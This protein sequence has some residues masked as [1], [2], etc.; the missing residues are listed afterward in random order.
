LGYDDDYCDFNRGYGRSRR[1]R[2][3]VTIINNNTT[4]IVNPTPNASP[5]P[6]VLTPEQI[7]E[8]RRR[9]ARTPTLQRVPFEGVV[10][11][12]AEE[13]GKQT[14]GIRTAPLAAAKEVLAKPV[15]PNQT[16]A[17]PEYASLKSKM[18]REIL[19]E[20][21]RLDAKRQEQVKTTGADMRETGKAL[22]Q[23]LE[24]ERIFGNRA[25]RK[26]EETRPSAETKSDPN[27]PRR[28]GAV[29]RRQPVKQDDSDADRSPDFNPQTNLPVGPTGGGK[30][31]RDER[32]E[33]NEQPPPVRQKTRDEDRT[34]PIFVKPSRSA[35]EP[36][37]PQPEKPREEEERRRPPQPTFPQQRQ[38]ERRREEPRPQPQPRREEVRPQ[39]KP[40]PEEKPTKP[41][42]RKSEKD[43]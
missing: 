30:S 43:S 31:E 12:S 13:F 35:P 18:S 22:N 23:K 14:R 7:N 37:A 4:V 19:I 2:R 5:T 41:I 25:P 20:T 38:E 3:N 1:N 42:N 15:D 39:P 24:N 32:Q 11:I 21:P 29:N 34:P 33:K 28:T 27:E 8:Q 17:L 10:A 40:E 6:P 36:P 26:I 9:N 16:P